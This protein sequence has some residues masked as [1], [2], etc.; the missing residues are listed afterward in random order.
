MARSAAIPSTHQASSWLHNM[1]V[2]KRLD[3]HVNMKPQ[4]KRRFHTQAPT[5]SPSPRTHPAMTVPRQDHT[6]YIMYI[7]RVLSLGG[8]ASRRRTM[9]I[10]Y[11]LTYAHNIEYKQIAERVLRHS[12]RLRLGIT[13][14]DRERL[15]L[16]MNRING[17]PLHWH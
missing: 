14:L 6:S 11:L 2:E 8:A 12:A 7:S 13:P 9:H 4:Q 3:V 15:L 17:S 10:E 1:A 16:T 5:P